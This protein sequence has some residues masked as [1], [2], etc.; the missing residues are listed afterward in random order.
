VTV[1]L[2]TGVTGTLGSTLVE[3]G[4]ADWTIRGFSRD[5][6][7]QAA[8]RAQHPDVRLL[9]GDVRDRK[10]L[11][12][13]C[14]GVDLVIHAAALKM[15][16]S[17][18]HDPAE[19]VKTNVDGTLNVIQACLDQNVDRAVFVS[20]DKAVHPTNLYGATKMVGERCWLNAN[21]YAGTRF[22]AVR[23]GNVT[24][25]RGSVATLNA[26]LL[27]HPD[28][29]RFW[30]T[31]REAVDIVLTAT[32]EMQGGEVFVPKI[33]AGKVADEYT[34]AADDPRGLLPG[35]KLHETLISPEEV[36]RTY[37][38]GDHYRVL[39]PGHKYPP[40]SCP[41]VPANFTYTSADA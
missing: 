19:V 32:R 28:V 33:R 1:V 36:D 38:W 6:H 17:G 24:G 14:N 31:R 23:Y 4:P 13:A 41:R 30:M 39:P 25:S 12:L 18:E 7:K 8:L 10:R 26:P 5:E 22:A 29:T 11:A 3:Y 2:V 21:A 27:R 16:H 9:L 37:D 40:S 15:V 34:F 20:S 35:E